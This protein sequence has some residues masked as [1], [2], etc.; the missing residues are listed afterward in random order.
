M[1]SELLRQIRKRAPHHIRDT[2]LPVEDALV[3]TQIS[4][5]LRESL[6]MD[7]QDEIPKS[8]DPVKRV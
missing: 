2:E 5:M 6:E 1:K 4:G 3:V 8:L 7:P